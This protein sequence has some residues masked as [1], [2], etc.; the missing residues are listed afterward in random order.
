MM[1]CARGSLDGVTNAPAAFYAA[2]LRDERSRGKAPAVCLQCTLR[3]VQSVG[4]VLNNRLPLK[5]HSRAS[6]TALWECG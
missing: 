5:W 4:F 2:L 6:G 3:R 1:T